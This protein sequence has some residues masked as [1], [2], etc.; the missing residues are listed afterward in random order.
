MESGLFP[1]PADTF[2]DDFERQLFRESQLKTVCVVKEPLRDPAS[3]S[4][5]VLHGAG[6]QLRVLI[7][8]NA[9]GDGNPFSRTIDRQT[10]A[11]GG[12]QKISV[13]PSSAVA[14]EHHAATQLSGLR[15][16]VCGKMNPRI[17]LDPERLAGG[18]LELPVSVR[19]RRE[20]PFLSVL[21][22]AGNPVAGDGVVSRGQGPPA[23]LVTGFPFEAVDF[24]LRASQ[25]QFAVRY[26]AGDIARFSAFR[27]G[28]SRRGRGD[29][30]GCMK[31]SGTQEV[32]EGPPGPGGSPRSGGPVDLAK[33][34]QVK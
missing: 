3:P 11:A 34:G 14:A 18:D 9:V 8:E 21:V 31:F 17:D 1:D 13:T 30:D 24:F 7:V 20:K 29:P 33:P 15:R 25:E 6:G 19:G 28:V 27:S 2:S 10:D 5:T 16:G 26:G 12:L 22:C 23:V 32:D 4:S